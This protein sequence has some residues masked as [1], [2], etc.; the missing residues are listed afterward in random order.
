MLEIIGIK[1]LVAGFI[2]I[3]FA[4]LFLE[5]W[6]A[7][8]VVKLL[9]VGLKVALKWAVKSNKY[10]PYGN[11]MPPAQFKP[12]VYSGTQPDTL[13]R[14]LDNENNDRIKADCQRR[15]QNPGWMNG[16]GGKA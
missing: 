13:A 7:L 1:L 5:I 14:S 11:E 15:S 6:G 16:N 9:F 8:F 10:S 2:G 12:S 4:G 3:C